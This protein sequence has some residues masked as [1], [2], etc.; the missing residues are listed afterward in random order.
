MALLTL[1]LTVF[2]VFVIGIA[3]LEPVYRIVSFIVL[4]IMLLGISLIY[5]RKRAK[6]VSRETKENLPEN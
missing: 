1:L 6:V 5:T 4:G 2:Y 3:K